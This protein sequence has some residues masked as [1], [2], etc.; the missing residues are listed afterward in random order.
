MD[1]RMDSF[2][3]PP[4]SL[5]TGRND[6]TMTTFR[7]TFSGRILSMARVPPK[8]PEKVEDTGLWRIRCALPIQE[9]NSS[10]PLLSSGRAGS[11]NLVYVSILP[12][13]RV[14]FGLD[15]PGTGGTVS[16]DLVP[17]ARGE[18]VIE[19]FIGPVATR[20][21]WPASWGVP[22]QALGRAA[23]SLRVW[24]DGRLVWRTK[25]HRPE[26]PDDPGADVGSNAQGFSTAA[27]EFPG[28]IRTSPYSPAEARAF[29][30]R[31]LEDGASGL[32]RIQCVLPLD[33]SAGAFP[34]IAGGVT[35][36]GAMVYVSVLPGQRARFGLDEWG[37]G[38]GLS[39]PFGAAPDSVHVI[40]IFD[41]SLAAKAG[42]PAAWGISA[43]RLQ[44][45]AHT[46]RIW[47]DG[48]LVWS[49][50]LRRPAGPKDDQIA[51]GTNFQGFSTAQGEFPGVIEFDPYEGDTGREF[52]GNNLRDHP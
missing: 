40:E 35:G 50:S 43:E 44:A 13:G 38:G 27:P 20:S 31:N 24:L 14:R 22:P 21:R 19:I 42:W 37:I 47:M 8:P 12:G 49:T 51:V 7:T 1:E 52:L 18:H 36:D 41:G 39:E 15:E 28:R 2:D 30:D 6:I 3:A 45:S 46:L 16:E 23:D 10:F 34:L 17:A 32:W 26:D 4:W 48:Q 33:H 25:L 9:V 11:G 5:E 29:L